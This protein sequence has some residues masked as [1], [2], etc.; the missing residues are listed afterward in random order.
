MFA[1]SAGKACTRMHLASSPRRTALSIQCAVSLNC[2]SKY[3]IHL[4]MYVRVCMYVYRFVCVCV[5][6]YSQTIGESSIECDLSMR[7]KVINKFQV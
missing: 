6:V 7:R 3:H 5:P 2:V 4:C 1:A